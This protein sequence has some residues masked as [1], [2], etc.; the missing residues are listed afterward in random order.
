LREE[1]CRHDANQLKPLAE[2]NR[3]LKHI[4]AERAVGVE[5]GELLPPAAVTFCL[6]SLRRR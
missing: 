2:E 4:V 5:D 3:Q 1:L 6:L